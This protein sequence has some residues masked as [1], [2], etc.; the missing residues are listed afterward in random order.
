MDLRTWP[1][2][3]MRVVELGPT[4]SAQPLPWP[5]GLKLS[6]DLLPCRESEPIYWA[7][8]AI[9]EQCDDLRVLGLEM[10]SQ[11][12]RRRRRIGARD[13]EAT[14]AVPKVAQGLNEG[15]DRALVPLPRL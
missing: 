3:R 5:L 1:L 13:P 2:L 8:S 11:G 7:A 14:F 15:L 4:H 6:D 9:T 12:L 10:T